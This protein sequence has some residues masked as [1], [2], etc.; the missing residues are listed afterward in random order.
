MGVT[1]SLKQ[2]SK[3]KSRITGGKESKGFEGEYKV[4]DGGHG[5]GRVNCAGLGTSHTSW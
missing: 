5:L 1:K 4:R 3:E 2:E